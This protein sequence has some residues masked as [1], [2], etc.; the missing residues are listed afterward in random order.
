MTTPAAQDS[1]EFISVMVPANRVMEVYAYLAKAPQTATQDNAGISEPNYSSDVHQYFRLPES[2]DWPESLLRRT[3]RESS[4]AMKA[5]LDVLIEKAG[6]TVHS[7][8]LVAALS[9]QRGKQCNHLHLA[10]T[11]GAFGRRVANRYQR[12]DWPM[13]SFWDSAANEVQYRMSPVVAAKMKP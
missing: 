10:G 1:T 2:T 11:I 9:K 13:Y 6:T 8:E 5:V 4:P 12:S 7:H 3:Y